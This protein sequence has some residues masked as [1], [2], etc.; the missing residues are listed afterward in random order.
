[1]YSLSNL[2]QYHCVVGCVSSV[3]A[4]LDLYTQV[5][6]LNPGEVEVFSFMQ[7]K[8]EEYKEFL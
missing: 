5:T 6:G 3:V 4:Y 2:N 7:R 8:K 1:M